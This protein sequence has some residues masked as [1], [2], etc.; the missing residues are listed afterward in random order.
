[1][2]GAVRRLGGWLLVP[3]LAS[4]P[5]A[6]QVAAQAPTAPI[7]PSPNRPTAEPGSE[8]TISVLTMG[9]G[10][11]VWERFGHNAIVVEDRAQGTSIAYNYGMFSF[12]QENFVLRFVQ[13]RMTYW[14]EGFDTD[15]DLAR[16]VRRQ[17]SVWQ[18]ELDLTPA[19]RVAMRDALAWNAR[20]EN[21]Y[22]KYDYY[23][24][25]CSTR[26]R[27]ALDRIVGGA[28]ERQ[29]RMPGSGS[30]RF[31]TQRLNTHNPPLY[32]G[33]T[34][35]LGAAADRPVTRWEEM[36]LP[37]KLRD[38]LREIRIPDGAG[39]FKPLVRA[40]R[41]LYESDAFPVPDAPPAWFP[42]FLLLGTAVG[43][44]LAWSGRRY[45]ITGRGRAGFVIPATIVALVLGLAG[46]ILAGMWAFTDHVATS[47]NQNVL[48]VTI[49]A[50]ALGVL[51]PLARP[52][53]PGVRR[54]VRS[55]AWLVV[56]LSLAGVLLKLLPV[57]HQVNGQ[58]LA[59]LVP[60]N[61]GLAFGVQAALRD[62]PAGPR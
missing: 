17:R 39:G 30:F 49:L 50:L 38:Y 12:T 19:E 59:L 62:E 33:L 6:G 57:G 24:D 44:W 3:M 40:E 53:R 36:F 25:N 42:W 13:G 32:F 56:G 18:Q 45:G 55:L 16:Y 11:E 31:H 21:R 52:A 51:L 43:G 29:S 58:V 35:L 27:D 4:A 5:V 54:A 2:R 41:A 9:V 61:L 23:L 28:I 48:Q 46:T 37:L 7:A 34:L 1:M 8:L 14:M 10:A 15:R 20:E 47:R 26:V 22:Y 60:I